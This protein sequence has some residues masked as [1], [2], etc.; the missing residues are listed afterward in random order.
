MFFPSP[1]SNHLPKMNIEDEMSLYLGSSP[2]D[3]E[4]TTEL[5]LNDDKGIMDEDTDLKK[6]TSFK[7]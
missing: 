3:S 1:N 7:T 6:K 5:E 2:F 4:K